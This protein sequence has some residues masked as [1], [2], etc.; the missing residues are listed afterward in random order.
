MTIR[1]I[2][3]VALTKISAI[4]SCIVMQPNRQIKDANVSHGQVCSSR[5]SFFKHHFVVGVP[6]L[7]QPQNG[8]QLLPFFL[9][10][11]AEWFARCD[12][13]GR[14]VLSVVAVVTATAVV[15]AKVSAAL[16]DSSVIVGP[17]D[18]DVCGVVA[19]SVKVD[20]DTL[21]STSVFAADSVSSNRAASHGFQALP[22]C[23]DSGDLGLASMIQHSKEE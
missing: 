4:F 16:A 9:T 6:G 2:T 23:T 19:V 15:A 22:V 14:A 5:D 7:D 1:T 13:L 21:S 17:V 20:G 10:E 12:S 18:A 8:Y 11:I 3:N